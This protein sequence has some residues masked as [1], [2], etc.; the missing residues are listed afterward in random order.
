MDSNGSGHNEHPAPNG[1]RRHLARVVEWILILLA[2]ALAVLVVF[3]VRDYLTLRREQ[4]LTARETALD[5]VLKAHGPLTANDAN[6]IQSWMT[7]DYVNRLFHLP[8]DYLKNAL[9]VAD[10]SYPRL[11]IGGYARSIGDTSEAALMGVQ[12]AVRGYLIKNASSTTSSTSSTLSTSSNP[13]T[14]T[15]VVGSI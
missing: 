3:A 4:V 8:T 2:I 14:T 10:T 11:S 12:A 15:T 1:E 6:I 13:L 7:F 9:P 5:G